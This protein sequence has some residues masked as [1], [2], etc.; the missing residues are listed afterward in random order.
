VLNDISRDELLC[1][2][3]RRDARL[4]TALA[5]D[6]NACIE[7]LHAHDLDADDTV[8]QAHA[9][10][11]AEI[12]AAVSTAL[13]RDLNEALVQ[14]LMLDPIANRLQ[15]GGRSESDQADGAAMQNSKAALARLL[16]GAG[17]QPGPALAEWYSAEPIR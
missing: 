3:I 7:A 15:S 1:K 13:P 4:I 17:A 10:R 16:M 12:E 8:W 6:A 5:A 11:L 14:V 9:V 2:F